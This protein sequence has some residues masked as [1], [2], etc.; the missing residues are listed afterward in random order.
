MPVTMADPAREYPRSKACDATATATS[1]LAAP[2][3]PVDITGIR[4]RPACRTSSGPDLRERGTELV[5]APRFP[6][7]SVYTS[8][9]SG[10]PRPDAVTASTSARASARPFLRPPSRVRPVFGGDGGRM[11]SRARCSRPASGP[12]TADQHG[13]GRFAR[14]A[15]PT[16]SLPTSAGR[17]RPATPENA[18]RDRSLPR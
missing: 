12:R 4:K 9:S 11:N 15:A 1:E 5:G 7:R 3:S 8:T 6:L 10:V 17:T 14:H 18:H 2:T 16:A 13:D